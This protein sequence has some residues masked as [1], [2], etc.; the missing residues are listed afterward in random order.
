LHD[1]VIR[2]L[3]LLGERGGAAVER[4]DGRGLHSTVCFQ[5]L[6]C[7]VGPDAAQTLVRRCREEA[8]HLGNLA[9]DIFYRA[10]VGKIARQ[11]VFALKPQLYQLLFR[12]RLDIRGRLRG[13][14]RSSAVQDLQ[15]WLPLRAAR[16]PPSHA[17]P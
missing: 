13:A 3:P 14:S 17:R 11:Q 5:R 6:P 16:L 10:A 8:L 7:R 2:L 15:P 9:L 12:S 1:A 4:A